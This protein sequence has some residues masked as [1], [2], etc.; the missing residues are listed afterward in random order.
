M[1]SMHIYEGIIFIFAR[2]ILNEDICS[3][4]LEYNLG[5][6][7]YY[8]DVVR[9]GNFLKD[10]ILHLYLLTLVVSCF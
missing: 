1:L 3:L 5:G 8:H 4:L 6:H 2:N 10:V 9:Y 7:G